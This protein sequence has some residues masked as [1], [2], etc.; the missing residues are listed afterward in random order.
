[1]RLTGC[2]VNA[3]RSRAWSDVEARGRDDAPGECI[4]LRS[5]A[6]GLGRSVRAGAAGAGIAVWDG[7]GCERMEGRLAAEGGEVA[8]GAAGADA[9]S[10]SEDEGDGEGDFDGEGGDGEGEILART[11]SGAS[12]PGA[13]RK[14]VR[15]TL[16]AASRAGRKRSEGSPRGV[17]A[18]RGERGKAAGAASAMTL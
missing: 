6:A 2:A 11:S 14:R 13:L 8:E 9:A 10:A 7:A 5:E 17:V 4:R 16:M 15:R 1:M 18:A 12:T 3:E